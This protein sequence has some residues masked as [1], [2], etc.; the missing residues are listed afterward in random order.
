MDFRKRLLELLKIIAYSG[1]PLKSI[2]LLAV[3][4]WLVPLSRDQLDLELIHD[5]LSHLLNQQA[6]LLALL[7]IQYKLDLLLILQA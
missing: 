1:K 4:E 5:F 6:L 3:P 7:D 2:N